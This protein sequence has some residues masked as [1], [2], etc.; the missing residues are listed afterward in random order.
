MHGYAGCDIQS[1][2]A[3][4]SSHTVVFLLTQ[5]MRPKPGNS[6]KLISFFFNKSRVQ[7]PTLRFF[8]SWFL[9]VASLL[10]RTLHVRMGLPDTI[11]LAVRQIRKSFERHYNL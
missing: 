7:F 2:L 3:A 8:L 10:P 1:L 9:F 11:V 5:R 6:T 4:T